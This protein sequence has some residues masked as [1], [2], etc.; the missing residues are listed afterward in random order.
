MARWRGRI[1]G[2]RVWLRKVE[3]ERLVVGRQCL[4]GRGR[5]VLSVCMRGQR[6]EREQGRE[7]EK[8]AAERLH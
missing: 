5:V 1:V 4:G 7:G 6:R 2:G 3:R 8:R